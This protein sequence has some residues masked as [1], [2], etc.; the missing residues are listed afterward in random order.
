M[1]AVARPRNNL[2]EQLAW[3]NSQKPHIPPRGPQA[4]YPQMP[5]VNTTLPAIATTA[6]PQ[7]QV[8]DLYPALR[9]EDT[10][11]VPTQPLIRNSSIPVPKRAEARMETQKVEVI[12][13]EETLIPSTARVGALER[14]K[15]DA[16][17]LGVHITILN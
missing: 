7:V 12:T 16:A 11:N 2:Q 4:Q 14:V 1:A 13:S 3:F 8:P 10:V 17:R 6:K 9:S 15:S 5:P